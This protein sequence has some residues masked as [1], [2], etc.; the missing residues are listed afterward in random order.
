ML[1]E[2]PYLQAPIEVLR[3]RPRRNG[4]TIIMGGGTGYR[5]GLD[6]FQ[7]HFVRT[8]PVGFLSRESLNHF[9]QM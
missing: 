4:G 8:S 2:E 1:R 6:T 5:E 9:V 3:G 7:L